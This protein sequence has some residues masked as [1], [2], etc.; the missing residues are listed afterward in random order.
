MS[1]SKEEEGALEGGGARAFALGC[2]GRRAGRVVTL[3]G[4]TGAQV[5][6]CASGGGQ[7]TSFVTG[8]V[9]RRSWGNVCCLGVGGVSFFLFF[10]FFFLIKYSLFKVQD[11]TWSA[12]Y[13]RNKITKQS[14]GLLHLVMGQTNTPRP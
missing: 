6:A 7:L 8:H 5:G 12:S 2:I 10:F 3:V 13:G 9:G 1:G 11:T 14:N 4:E